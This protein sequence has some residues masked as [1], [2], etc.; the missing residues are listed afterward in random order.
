MA[1]KILFSKVESA[2]IP[3]AGLPENGSVGRRWKFRRN[4]VIFLASQHGASQ[5]LLAD[6]FDLPHSRIAAVIKEFRTKYAG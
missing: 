4:L 1:N 3:L 5:R 2:S 6:V